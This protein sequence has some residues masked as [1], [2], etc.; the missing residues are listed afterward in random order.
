[1]KI[2]ILFIGKHQKGYIGEAIK[3]YQERLGH[4][5]PVEWIEA[6]PRLPGSGG[7]REEVMRAEARAA[8]KHLKPGD[9][10]VLLDERGKTYSSEAFSAWLEEL[11]AGQRQAVVFVVGGPFGFHESLVSRAV[12][13]LSMSPMT[14]THQLVRVVFLEQLYRAMKIMRNEK[15]HY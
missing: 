10:V 3:D 6:V 2:K 11:F 15:Y 13:R 8:E 1:V 5:I 14:M 7:S 4:Y 12:M 9:F